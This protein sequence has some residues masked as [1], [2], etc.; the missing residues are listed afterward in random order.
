M[1]SL[2]EEKSSLVRQ[3]FFNA[4][5][6]VISEVLCLFQQISIAG[7]KLSRRGHSDSEISASTIYSR[8]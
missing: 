7:R 4:K 3:T 5:A 2:K 8:Q 6:D 1:D